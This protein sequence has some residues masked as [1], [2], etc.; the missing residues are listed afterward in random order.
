METWVG[1]TGGKKQVPLLHVWLLTHHPEATAL[2]CKLLVLSFPLVGFSLMSISTTVHF[3]EEVQSSTW[4][5][6]GSKCHCFMEGVPVGE[7]KC[8]GTTLAGPL[9]RAVN[10]S[11]SNALSSAVGRAFPA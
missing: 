2:Q 9:T 8:M 11:P 4:R 5:D 6:C 3:L 1:G 10:G 7:A